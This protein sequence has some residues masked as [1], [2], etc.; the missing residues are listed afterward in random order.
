MD[1]L[2][3]SPQLQRALEALGLTLLHSFWQGLVLMILLWALFKLIQQEKANL[4]FTLY[5]KLYVAD[6]AAFCFHL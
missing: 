1:F 4:R 2:D 5:T 6:H 3:Y